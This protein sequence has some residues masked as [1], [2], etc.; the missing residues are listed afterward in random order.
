MVSKTI[1]AVLEN[2]K[3]PCKTGYDINTGNAVW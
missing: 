3:L 1:I 2:R